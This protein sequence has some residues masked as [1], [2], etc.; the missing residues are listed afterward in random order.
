MNHTTAQ[1]SI[2]R[3]LG[4]D[5]FA[6]RMALEQRH[7]EEFARSRLHFLHRDNWFSHPHIIRAVLHLTGM[8][9]RGRRNA[10][11]MTLRRNVVRS[12]TLPAAFEGFTILHLS[13]IHADA[14]EGAL[15]RLIECVEDLRYD[16]CCLTGDYRADS[17]GDSTPA[18]LGMGR[19]MERLQQPVFAV[20]GN[21]D[22]IDVIDGLERVGA[23]ML[24]NESEAIS[25]GDGRIYLAGIDDA[26][27]FHTHDIRRVAA[28]IPAG[29]FSVLLSHT[30]ETFHDAERAGFS[31]MLS[32]HTHGGQICLPGSIPII[33]DA[34]LPRRYGA[35]A[36]WYGAMQGYTSVGAGTSIVPVR[37]N[38]P[39]EITLHELRLSTPP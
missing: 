7:E 39:P 9:R 8:Y 13:D 26:H 33:L 1:E 5:G 18:L 22:S 32:G 16:I 3:R 19:L 11:A 28:Q 29:S 31:L 2:A 38:C 24:L 12:P 15:C 36:W 25:R 27:F 10:E 37:F 6:R 34:K 35:G 4:A 14:H 21:H 17:R 20:P 30:P 23:R